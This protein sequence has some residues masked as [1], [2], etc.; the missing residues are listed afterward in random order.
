MGMRSNDGG[1]GEEETVVEGVLGVEPVTEDDVGD[2]EGED[3]VEIAHLLGAVLRDDGGGVEQALGDDDGVADGDGL[4]RLGE[5][6]AAA[7]GTGEGD[8]V[9]GE[10]IAGESFEGLVE[11]AG[12]ID[13]AGLEEAVD[14]VVF[15][16]LDPGALGAERAYILCIIADVGGSDDIE[17]GVLGLLGGDFEDVTPDVVD[18]LE[19]EGAGDA[20][21][22]AL[23]NVEGGGQPEVGLDVGAPAVEVV[24]LL[25]ILLLSGEVAVEADDVAAAG[26]DPDAA[27]EATGGTLAGDGGDVEDGG[28]SVAEE[29][30]A[31]VAEGVVLPVEV[32][33]VHEDHLDEAGFVEVEVEAA[34]KT[35]DVGHRVLEEA[36]LAVVAGA[37]R[38]GLVDLVGLVADDLVELDAGED[39]AGRTRGPGRGQDRASCSGCRFRRGEPAP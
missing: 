2:L 14:D 38:G 13:E 20:L 18:G 26:L 35:G 7:D 32:V 24:E 39:S 23:L 5:Q 11:L 30:V 28:G 17:G 36:E 21:G 16:L 27:E 15:S 3:C 9:V 4:E 33:R 1:G 31:D 6:R 34:A 12:C 29:V 22:I 37:L 8:V 19:L 25:V 10:D